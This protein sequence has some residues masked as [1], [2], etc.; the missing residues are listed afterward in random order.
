MVRCLILLFICRKLDEEEVP[1]NDKKEEEKGDQGVSEYALDDETGDK[2][3]P[4]EEKLLKP[5]EDEKKDEEKE[6]ENEKEDKGT[7]KEEPEAETKIDDPPTDNKDDDTK[8][9]RKNEVVYAQLDMAKPKDDKPVK[10][11]STEY[12]DIDFAR[13]GQPTAL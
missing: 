3:K 7:E 10:E 9:P 12:A 1:L 11:P 2:K 4:E 13:S 8:G 6:N 5:D